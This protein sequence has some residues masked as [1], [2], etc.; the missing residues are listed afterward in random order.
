M[1]TDAIQKLRGRIPGADPRIFLLFEGWL[2]A[3]N[4][5]QVA[6]RSCFDPISISRM[7][8]SVWIYRMVPDRGDYVCDLAGE[9][10]NTVWG[11][12]IRGRTLTEIVGAE[13]RS[14]LAERWATARGEPA[15]LYSAAENLPD[16]HFVYRVERLVLP[17]RA[18][19]GEID[20]VLGVSLYDRRRDRLAT[21]VDT[22]VAM[23]ACVVKIAVA[24]L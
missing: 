3:R 2:A 11:S 6:C 8:G 24:D 1:V 18:K 21:G 4:G 14:T 9:E 23:P 19:S 16:P 5:Y 10:V 7:L 12:S 15:I 17:M 20:S 13:H 22:S